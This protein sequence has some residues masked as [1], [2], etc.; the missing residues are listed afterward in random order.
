[1]K[2]GMLI[3]MPMLFIIQ[4]IFGLEIHVADFQG[5]TLADVTVVIPQL[6]I[7][8]Y[9]DE[10]GKV[11]MENIPLGTYTL[12][13]VLPGYE[14]W[15]STITVT[16]GVDV[17][18]ITLTPA[19][20]AVEGVTISEKRNK[21]TVS[22]QTTVE[23]EDFHRTSEGMLNDATNTLKTLPGIASSGNS[24][25]SSMYIQGGARDE[26]VAR[27]DGI[28]IFM[29]ERW[30]G[31]LSMFN[32]KWIDS[33]DMYTAGY[34]AQFGQG[35]SGILDV[36]IKDGK[37]GRFGGFF[38]ISA[39]G[40]ELLLNGPITEN[41]SLFFDMRRTYY[42]WIMNLIENAD[43]GTI[44]YPYL[45]DG[46]LKLTFSVSDND[47]LS[48]L[49]YG[50][51]EGMNW[52]MIG[53][54]GE[55]APDTGH[56]VYNSFNFVGMLK[57]EHVFDS[58][59]YFEILF[60]AVPG[61]L[62]SDFSGNALIT[63]HN[64]M[65]TAPVQLGADF[66]LNSLENHSLTIGCHGLMNIL[67]GSADATVSYMQADGTWVEDE[68]QAVILNNNILYFVSANIM[69][70]W[71][72]FP[73]LIIQLGVW[74]DYFTGTNEIKIMPRGGIKYEVID[75][76][77]VFVRAG[78]Y[79]L[80]PFSP[81][82]LDTDAGNPA[83]LGKEAVHITSGVDFSNDSY[84]LL[85]EGFYKTYNNLVMDDVVLNYNNNGVREVWGFD[86]YLQKKAVDDDWINGWVS[87]TWVYAREKVTERSPETP[88]EGYAS[89]LNEWYTP[90]YAREHTLSSVIELT[91][92]ANEYTP[93]LNWLNDWKIS[94]DFRFMTGKT[95]TPTVDALKVDTPADGAQYLYIRGDYL[96]NT[97]PPIIKL[98]IKVSIPYSLFSLINVFGGDVKTS[99][100]ISF[101]NVLNCR[102]I[103][104]Y[105]YGVDAT[106]AASIPGGNYV[107]SSAI[108]RNDFIDTPF[109]VLGGMK[110]EF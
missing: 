81:F 110:V 47:T 95:Y 83:L 19:V 102:N 93:V 21:G 46:V 54:E 34:P 82:L 66:Y 78:L 50:S 48:L 72:L 7:E 94:F 79:N 56:F 68:P 28:Y 92:H 100:Y 57:Y 14:K 55:N 73:N 52:D 6:L 49:G 77:A 4:G 25:D 40:S 36:K 98:D 29:P 101:I 26:W 84:A 61:V 105:G 90:D 58:D 9:T 91:Y 30:G 23:N 27:M 3:V 76:L 41:F 71:E 42:D 1:M 17:I 11:I 22:D 38:D 106:A 16:E 5:K 45:W 86:V 108:V 62:E 33:I 8:D 13:A 43:G 32:P 65:N 109:I 107:G 37:T 80:H 69:D 12:V 64:T 75:D 51:W 104:N 103:I 39:I 87:Y 10:D 99:S 67:T 15:E 53:I 18:N 88:T 44:Q 63:S 85:I 60:G 35:L 2:P 70:D 24:F 89:P 97:T 59:D 20:I 96:S 31:N 74:T